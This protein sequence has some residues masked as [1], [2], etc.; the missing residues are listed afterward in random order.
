MTTPEQRIQMMQRAETKNYATLLEKVK[1]FR[2][3]DVEFI[4]EAQVD[5]IVK[6]L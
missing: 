3:E 6:K 5:E 2:M 4:S 1:E